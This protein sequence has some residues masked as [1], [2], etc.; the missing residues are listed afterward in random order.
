M[1]DTATTPYPHELLVEAKKKSGFTDQDI[2]DKAELS[3]PTV[4]G[5]LKG[6]PKARPESV[7]AVAKALGVS[8]RV[9]FEKAA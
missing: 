5:V 7:V 3:R 1:S 4:A 8:L 6:D 9:R 2:A